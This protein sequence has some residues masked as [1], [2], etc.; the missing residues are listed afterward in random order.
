M[1]ILSQ[2]RN[3][4]GL[5]FVFIIIA[6]AA[7]LI[8][9]ALSSG[10]AISSMFNNDFSVGEIAGKDISVQAFQGRFQRNIENSGGALNDQ[11]RE[12]VLEQTWQ[13]LVNEVIFDQELSSAG[14]NVSEAEVTDLLMGENPHPTV[15][16]IQYFWDS[17]GVYNPQMV[18]TIMQISQN[19]EHPAQADAARI[20]S[21]VIEYLYNVRREEKY[22]NMLKSGLLVSS[23]EA[24]FL[25][26]EE[27]RT[28]N[29]S[30]FGVNYSV[31]QDSTPLSDADYRAYFNEHK[32][33]FKQ[34]YRL[35]DQSILIAL[36]DHPYRSLLHEF[37]FQATIL[38]CLL[39]RS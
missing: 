36:L 17:T 35:F 9:D 8:S 39:D 29:V 34:A 13:Q 19:V 7:F 12:Q 4:I 30:F 5:V 25:N 14:L 3:R 15:K 6:L 33:E 11:Q 38:S 10:S 27:T 31:V 20:I 21:E 22:M 32:E 28:Y 16:Q 26:D 23:N 2:I 1:A 18:Q 37:H 24:R